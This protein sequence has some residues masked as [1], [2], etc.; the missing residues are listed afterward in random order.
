MK[1]WMII[2]IILI[3]IA[4]I[5]ALVCFLVYKKS[6]KK[7]MLESIKNLDIKKNILNSKPVLVE[8]SKIE[9]I[10]KNEQLEEKINEFKIRYE[11]IK[12]VK[13]VKINDMIVELDVLLEKRSNKEFYNQYADIELALEDAEYSI[14]EILNRFNLSIFTNS[15]KRVAKLVFKSTP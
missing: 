1:T 4:F 13:I 3:S 12:T 7:K 5:V 9:E 2:L 10:A 11:E 6:K 8:L 14:D 15:F